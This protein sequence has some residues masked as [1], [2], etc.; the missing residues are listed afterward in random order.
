MYKQIDR[1]KFCQIIWRIKNRQIGLWT[2]RRMIRE[3]DRWMD[4]WTDKRMDRQTDG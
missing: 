4:I 3:T 1:Q 2:D